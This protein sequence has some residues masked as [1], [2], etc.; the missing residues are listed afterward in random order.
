MDV[1]TLAAAHAAERR[2]QAAGAVLSAVREWRGMDPADLASSWLLVGPRITAITTAGQL[3]AA[4]SAQEYVDGA[5]RAQDEQPTPGGQVQAESLAGIASDGRPLDSLLQV[6][7]VTTRQALAGGAGPVEAMG[8]GERQLMMLVDTQVADAGR[9]AD[10]VGVTAGRRVTGYIRVISPSACGRCAVL[11]GN[12]YASA[13]AFQRHPHCHCQHVPAVRG[14]QLRRDVTD[15][16][17]YFRALSRAEQD[18]AFGVAGAQAIR[19]GADIGQVVNARRSMYSA[20]L[21]PGGRP[22]LATHE[23][24]TRRG[25]A[26]RRLKAERTRGRAPARVRLMPEAIYQLASDR[27]DA[28]R[29]LYRYGYLY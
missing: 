3:A 27:E 24:M 10:G 9:V 20:G 15:P 4:R 26:A 23:G 16:A 7:L 12:W 13:T 14:G 5:V 21:A 25:L 19:D 28:I 18:R 17:S 8:L 11:A 2:R 1:L 22:L 6:P 29:L